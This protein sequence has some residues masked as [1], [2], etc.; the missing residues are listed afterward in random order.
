MSFQKIKPKED[1]SI[2][3]KCPIVESY[4]SKSYKNISG[5][6]KSLIVDLEV[7]YTNGTNRAETKSHQVDTN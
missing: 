3:F 6:N 1:D 4:K 5:F 2:P 7:K